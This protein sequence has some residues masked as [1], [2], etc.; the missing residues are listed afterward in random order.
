MNAQARQEEEYA[1]SYHYVSRFEQSFGQTTHD[2]PGIHYA[3]I[4]AVS[5]I[6]IA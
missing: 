2:G 3:S 6:P 1:L 4:I 5:T